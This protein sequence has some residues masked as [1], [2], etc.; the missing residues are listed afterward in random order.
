MQN[1]SKNQ[2]ILVLIRHGMTE[3][4][5]QHRYLGKTDEAL[6]EEGNQELYIYS[7]QQCYPSVDVL[8]TS[9]MIRCIRTA[10]ILYPT[11]QSFSIAEWT[12]MDFGAFEGKNYSELCKDDRYQAWIDSN[13]TLPFPDGESREDFILRS[14]KG[15]WQMWKEVQK[16][17]KSRKI[18]AIG[19]I[20]HG[21]TIMALLSRF[22]GGDYFDYQ[23]P[24]GNGYLCTVNDK[25]GT[26]EFMTMNKIF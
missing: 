11:L 15:F 26:P 14:E 10:E 7:K 22:Y 21:G 13:G 17:Q 5:K 20:V 6:S 1:R 24:N 3:A 12:E 19:A 9:P 8:F 16:I 25:N 23:V 18:N 2:M 4:N